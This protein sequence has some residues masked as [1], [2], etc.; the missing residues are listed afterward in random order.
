MQAYTMASQQK[1]SPGDDVHF[2]H[3]EDRKKS[4]V[5]EAWSTERLETALTQY[6][7][8]CDETR[9][10]V[11]GHLQALAMSL[12][13]RSLP[14]ALLLHCQY[15]NFMLTIGKQDDQD[16]HETIMNMDKS[17][18]F[19]IGCLRILLLD[20]GWSCQCHRT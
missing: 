6:R 4:I 13:V 19:F 18:L 11:R 10:A 8:V 14:I 1:F 2:L 5:K 17:S 20:F 7:Q 3:P 12:Q 9:E 15:I 16:Q